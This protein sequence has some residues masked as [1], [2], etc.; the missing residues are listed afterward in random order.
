MGRRLSDGFWLSGSLVPEN[1]DV[2][3]SFGSVRGPVALIEADF[4][5]NGLQ[6][7]PSGNASGNATAI[8]QNPY[9]RFKRCTSKDPN[10]ICPYD[11]LL[12]GL[13]ALQSKVNADCP[14]C[15]KYVFNKL[16]SGA[17]RNSSPGL[18]AGFPVFL[19]ARAQLLKS[20]NFASR[21]QPPRR[22][23]MRATAATDDLGYIGPRS[24][25]RRF[26]LRRNQ[27]S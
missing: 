7:A 10:A 14:D 15:V 11:S 3:E 9:P 13:Q 20:P 21:G 16:G 1:I 8:K 26:F 4:L 17:I 12:V 27:V 6:S 22:P 19:T 5:E 23:Q 18:S 25:C 24:K 2:A